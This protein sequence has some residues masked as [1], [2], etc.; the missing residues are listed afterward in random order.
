MSC[1]ISETDSDMGNKKKKIDT[2]PDPLFKGFCEDQPGPLSDFAYNS[3]CRKCK[4]LK[5][6]AKWAEDCL[7]F[8]EPPDD[9]SRWDILDV[10]LTGRCELFNEK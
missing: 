4:W 5:D 8:G 6:G 3:I 1:M 9:L 7:N 2:T 10:Q